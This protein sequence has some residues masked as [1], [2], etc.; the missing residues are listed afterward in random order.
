VLIDAASAGDWVRI[1]EI[2]PPELANNDHLLLDNVWSNVLIT[3]NVFG[4]IRVSPYA[5]AARITHDVPSVSPTVVVST[6]DRNILAI[7]SEVR[8]ALGNGVR[9]FLV[10]VGDT[11]P[12]VDHLADHYEI[13]EH[14]RDLRKSKLTRFEVGMPTRFQRWQF[15]KRI[16][17]GAE[18]F[19]TGPILDPDTVEPSFDKLGRRNEDPPVFLMVI[20]PFNPGW[21][22]QMESMGAVP[23]TDSFREK[24]AATELSARR[25][26]GWRWAQEIERRAIDVGCAG[27]ILM[28]LKYDTVV[29]EAAAA[30]RNND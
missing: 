14:L 21:V 29:D 25:E 6:R 10:V 24:L 3:D 11:V 5:F 22:S 30:W 4:K 18:F 17:I 12:H 13:V 23:T 20:P 19:V 26:E 16:D 1:P 28:G 9:S 7:E 8:G 15:R 27:V 2:N